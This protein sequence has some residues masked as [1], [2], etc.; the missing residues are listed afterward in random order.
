MRTREPGFTLLEVTFGLSILGVIAVSVLATIV[1]CSKAQS[2]YRERS[3]AREAARAQMERILAWR[4]FYTLVETFDGHGFSAGPL[5]PVPLP[6]SPPPVVEEGEDPPPPPPPPLPG[7]VSVE[8]VSPTLVRVS[9]RVDWVSPA[10]GEESYE[11][12][13]AIVDDRLDALVDVSP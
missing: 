2:Y 9:V 8:K 11:L 1:T 13:S 12:T 3:I 10:R 5:E 4:E 7:R 6:P